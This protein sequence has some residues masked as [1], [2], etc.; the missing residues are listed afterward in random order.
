MGFSTESAGEASSRAS[1]EESGKGS[2]RDSSQAEPGG[3]NSA[4]ASSALPLVS[5]VIPAY[6]AHR[7][8]ARTLNSVLAQTYSN[9]EI[10][11]VNDGSPDTELLEEALQ[12]FFP[13]IR[14]IK[15]E[16][17]G[18]SGARN[19][20]IRDARG[21]Y[22][23]F[24]DSDDTW[25]P[26]H[27]ATQVSLLVRDPSLH[28]VYSDS[29]LIRGERLLGN[30]FAN[31]P[32]HPPV[33]FEKLL[34]EECTVMTSSTVASREA[35]MAAGLFD[36]AFV[37]CEDFDLWLRMAFRGSRMDYSS[38]PGIHHY[39]TEDSLASDSYLLKRAR[40]GVYEK[41][42]KTMA[43]SASQRSLVQSLINTTEARCQ[44]ELLKEYLR[45]GDY[46]KALQAAAGASELAPGD[47]KLQITLFGLRRMP[48]VFRRV[49]GLHEKFLE[50]RSKLRTTQSRRSLEISTAKLGESKP[51]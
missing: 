23:A 46:E 9:L 42:A 35:M 2:R 4:T 18:P 41:T 32:Q 12:P 51:R 16:N 11:L 15:Q 36:E 6:N 24:L 14:Y 29:I 26:H 39:L 7:Y 28:L 48:A 3:R 38:Q 50:F 45:T 34:T 49:H 43:L 31:E 17:R 33:S 5:V 27:L 37:R 44:K 1:A 19:R 22:V 10:L 13:K 30:S 25:L 20:A 21:V 8:I 47:R 40:I